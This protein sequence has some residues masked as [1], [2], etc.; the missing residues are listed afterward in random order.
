M[1]TTGAILVLGAHPEPSR[2]AHRAMKLL[3]AHG[4]EAT[5][6]NPRFAEVLGRTC[7]ASPA[8]WRE[9]HPKEAVDTVTFY[10]NPVHSSKLKTELVDLRP[11]RAIFNPG[12]ENP[13]LARALRD[14]G[15][16]VIEDCT[17][18]MLGGGRF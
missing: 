1:K 10:L 16:E 11:R 5:P 9:A 12:S 13:D 2:F 8:A 4:F 15:V 3:E 18:V 17:L 6:I 7:Y 14:K